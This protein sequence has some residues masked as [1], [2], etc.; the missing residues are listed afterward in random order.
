MDRAVTTLP[1]YV[2]NWCSTGIVGKSGTWMLTTF[3]AL[4]ASFAMPLVA[5]AAPNKRAVIFVSP[6][7]TTFEE[8]VS[9]PRMI[10]EDAYL[11]SKGYKVEVR[12]GDK[13]E[14]LKSLLD[15]NVQAISY[16][17]HGS[18]STMENLDAQG[19]RDTAK[20]QLYKR[21]IQSGL[22]RE[23]ALKKVE[24]HNFGKDLVRNFSCFSLADHSLAHTLVKP[25]GSYF[26]TPKALV[27][28]PTPRQLLTDEAFFLTEYKVP[29]APDII[30]A[31]V[32]GNLRFENKLTNGPRQVTAGLILRISVD[33]VTG[34]FAATI[35]YA[36]ASAGGARLTASL[37]GKIDA[38]GAISAKISGKFEHSQSPVKATDSP[39]GQSLTNV[40]NIFGALMSGTV[41]GELQGVLSGE[42]AR[43][44]VKLVIERKM[45]DQKPVSIAGNWDGRK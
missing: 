24:A 21:Y 30:E 37:K 42:V 44:S 36:R 14:I 27:N 34:N 4:M 26:G 31:R 7:M 16:F 43:G 40:G 10:V 25:G 35:P 2:A 9:Q 19:W 45:K 13:K 5:G 8:A 6:G 17:G 32:S 23:Q 12:I 29:R 22:P 28:C 33:N 1:D 38:K 39:M 11:R 20:S 15:G 18:G 3:I 41:R